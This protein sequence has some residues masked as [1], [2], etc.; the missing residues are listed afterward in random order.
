MRQRPLVGRVDK[1]SRNKRPLILWHCW[2]FSKA[3]GIIIILTAYSPLLP[4]FASATGALQGMGI[5]FVYTLQVLP[6]QT[7]PL[8]MELELWCWNMLLYFNIWSETI[9]GEVDSGLSS[10]DSV[11]GDVATAAV[12]LSADITDSSGASSFTWEDFPSHQRRLGSESFKSLEAWPPTQLISL[13]INHVKATSQSAFYSLTN[14]K[15]FCP[16]GI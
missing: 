4:G 15:A 12:F 7:D 1:C 3:S 2:I 11:G 16:N 5:G 14:L 9:G 10:G 6:H 13:L 8:L